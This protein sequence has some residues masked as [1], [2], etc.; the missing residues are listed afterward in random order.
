MTRTTPARAPLWLAAFAL[1]GTSP[2]STWAAYADD[3]GF[4]RLQDELGAASVPTGAGVA[5][6]QIEGSVLVNSQSTW[7]PD[8]NNSEF[9]GKSIVDLSGA[10]DGLYSGHA[11]GVGQSYYGTASSL[12]PAITDISVYWASDWLGIGYLW[13]TGVRRPATSAARVANHSWVGDATTSNGEVL[14]RLDWVIETDDVVHVV[15]LN[16]GS[17]AAVRPLL[18]SSFNAIAA[19]RSDGYHQAGSVAVD[20]TYTA[21]RTRPDVVVP[22]PST[23]RAAPSVSSIVALLVE[24]AHADASLS[25]DPT[26]QGFTN[27]AGVYVRNAGRVEV[28]KAALM[29]GA[30]RVTRNSSSA[31]LALYRATAAEQS[32]NGLDR[33]YGAGQ[34]NVANSYLILASGEQNSAEDGG[35]GSGTE[36]RG[37]DY[38]P[39]FGGLGGANATATYALPAATTPQLLTATLAWNLDVNGGTQNSFSAAA[40]LRDLALAVLDVTDPSNPVTVWTSQS[41]VE[42]TENAWLVV[43]A[44]ARYALR[45][46]RGS[47]SAFS[48]DYGIAWQLLPDTDGD[49]AH[50]GHDNCTTVANG[51]ILRDAGGYSQRDTDGDGYG[52]RC[53]GDIDNSGGIVNYSDL[54]AFRAAYGTANANADLDGSGGLVNAAD[55][56]IFRTLF[57]K[58]P[59]PSSYAP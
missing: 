55:L 30:D 57:A 51:P 27:R 36:P 39:A 38:D 41:T 43:P 58:P 8:V 44:G 24:A 10:P 25:T 13:A 21:E 2:G 18:G 19:G 47:G 11:T 5:V 48:Y 26:S 28:L 56:A 46:T 29:A 31:D 22:A 37:F 45:V 6:A 59:G 4:R 20:A 42:N 9:A 33:R 50:D 14:A 53:D 49:G 12:S 35:P 32:T 7:A 54:G 1:L 34:A 52:N 15:G 17:G 3:V 16:N 23:S 40:T